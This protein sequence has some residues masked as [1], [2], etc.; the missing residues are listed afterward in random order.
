MKES[1]SGERL[2]PFAGVEERALEILDRSLWGDMALEIRDVEVALALLCEATSPWLAAWEDEVTFALAE[3]NEVD[4]DEF[5]LTR[6][7][8]RDL[9]D[10]WRLAYVARLVE[11]LCLQYGLST[12]IG[13]NGPGR[14][15]EGAV[16]PPAE[17]AND[18]TT[19][20]FK[21]CGIAKLVHRLSDLLDEK[22]LGAEPC[23]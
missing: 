10:S 22:R 6:E 12:T 19:D 15:P 16:A 5:L 17:W 8:V 11:T 14:S 13:A 1:Q 9:S 20:H 7:Q 3:E 2:E 4:V 21:T 18:E 23:G